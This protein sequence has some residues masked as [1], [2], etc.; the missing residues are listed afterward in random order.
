LVNST[1]A[2]LGISTPRETHFLFAEN[3]SPFPVPVSAL[4]TLCADKEKK[5][6]IY[7]P[8]FVKPMKVSG[9]RFSALSEAR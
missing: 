2:A 3:E 6:L 4:E 5:G 7:Y 9:M 1:A 8:A